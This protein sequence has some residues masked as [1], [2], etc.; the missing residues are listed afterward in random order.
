[1]MARQIPSDKEMSWRLLLSSLGDLE[2]KGQKQLPLIFGAE[3]ELR[4]GSVDGAWDSVGTTPPA[5]C[6]AFF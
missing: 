4:Q 5:L 3:E 1:M 2:G 6:L